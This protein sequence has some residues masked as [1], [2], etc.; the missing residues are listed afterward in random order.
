LLNRFYGLYPSRC[1]AEEEFQQ[2]NRI[3]IRH[4]EYCERYD[5]WST[6]SK[7]ERI[8]YY[9]KNFYIKPEY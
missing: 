6:Y 7:A 2:A 4:K 3:R 9:A 1:T 5:D 8:P